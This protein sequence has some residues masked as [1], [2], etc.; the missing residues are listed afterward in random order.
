[1]FPLSERNQ[2]LVYM[3][4]PDGTDI[5]ETEARALEVSKW[6]ADPAAESRG[7]Q[8]HPLRGGWR[9]T[10]LPD[11]D[12]GSAGSGL[13]LF[14][15]QHEGLRGGD[16]RRRPCMEVSLR[17]SSGSAF[18]DQA[19]WRWGRWKRASSMSK[20]RGLMP[21]ASLRSASRC[22][23]CSKARPA[24]GTTTTTG[25]TRSS[26]SSWTST[27]IGSGSWESRRRRSLSALGTYFTGTTVS[28]YREGDNLIPIALRG[29]VETYQSLEGLTSATFAK[30][31]KLIPLAQIATLRTGL[32]FARIRRKNQERTI[33]VNGPQRGR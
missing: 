1:M 12:A 9:P 17:K 7:C 15:G 31:G 23:P 11:I 8:P 32:D 5:S 13:G 24:S 27:R 22:D 21:I 26:R 2:F 28:T 16:P 10:V 19:A 25:A 20:S 33:I 30:D 29:G 3:N 14:P 18:Q 6:L 4:M